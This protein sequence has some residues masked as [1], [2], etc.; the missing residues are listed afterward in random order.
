MSKRLFVLTALI[1]LA[2]VPAEWA[3][4]QQPG[5]RPQVSDEVRQMC[6]QAL[7]QLCNPGSP[8]GLDA[9]RRCAAENKDK[10]PAQCGALIAAFAQPRQ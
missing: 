5:A 2:V 6:R 8:P 10:L 4:A 9:V 3:I 1:A 7:H